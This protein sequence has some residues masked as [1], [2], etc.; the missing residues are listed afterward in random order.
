MIKHLFI[1][2]LFCTSFSALY[3]QTSD[4]DSISVMQQNA[5]DTTFTDEE[6]DGEELI[7]DTIV[8]IHEIKIPLDTIRSWKSKKEYAYVKNLD[9]LLKALQE[10]Q[11]IN[12]ANNDNEPKLSWLENIFNG[13]MLK[14]ILWMLAAF[15]VIVV[16]YQLIKNG[17]MFKRVVEKGVEEEELTVEEDLL[18]QE[19][20]K[21]LQKAFNKGDYR[22]AIRY[23]FLKT[24]K[25]LLDKNQI[26]FAA[27][28]TNSQYVKE[29]P[30]KWRNEFAGLILNYEYIWYG[31]FALSADQYKQLQ[32]KYSSFNEKI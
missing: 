19:F 6:V 29:V 27:N 21:L 10:Q 25:I 1:L 16:L 22:L 28:K 13:S 14:I 3:A 23:Q 9:S 5:Y 4:D 2:F 30:I 8:N 7:I 17:G 31:N 15:F 11:E 24:L 12:N 32:L 26:E 20:D 18:D